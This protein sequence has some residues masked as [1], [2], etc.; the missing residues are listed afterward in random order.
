MALKNCGG[1]W[2]KD[3]KRGKFMSGN[4]E[5]EGKGGPKYSF[6]VFKN[7]DKKSSK[8]PDYRIAMSEDDDVERETRR[9]SQVDDM[10]DDDNVPF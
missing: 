3:G 4:F 6:L 1:L 8:H 10:N 7:E 2:L 9:P 5:P